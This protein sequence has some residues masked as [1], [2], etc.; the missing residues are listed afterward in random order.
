MYVYPNTNV[1]ILHNIPLDNGY[2]NTLYFATKQAQTQYFTGKVK[3]NFV[4]CTYQRANSNVIKVGIKVEDL[5][6]CNYLMFQ[7]ESFGNKWFYAFILEVNYV[8][9]DVSEIKYEI[10]VMQ[11]WFFDYTLEQCF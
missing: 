9:N 2:R 1:K 10:D 3:H 8:N 11:T 4:Q 5:Y 7:N 6:D